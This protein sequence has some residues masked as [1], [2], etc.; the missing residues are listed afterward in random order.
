MRAA[1]YPEATFFLFLSGLF[2]DIQENNIRVEM[3]FHEATK[4]QKARQGK[5]KPL[6]E[7]TSGAGRKVVSI[8]LSGLQS[9]S[10]SKE[11]IGKLN[12]GGAALKVG[13]NVKLLGSTSPLF[14][15]SIASSCPT[16]PQWPQISGVT[17]V[18]KHWNGVA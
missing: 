12:V 15:L 6:S 13:E 11:E 7:T 1:I 3:A 5:E 2:Y 18:G 9:G 16:P 17:R 14:L 8:S 4:L 10:A